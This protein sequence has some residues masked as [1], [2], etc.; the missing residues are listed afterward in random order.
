MFRILYNVKAGWKCNRGS[1]IGTRASLL[2]I[3]SSIYC[4]TLFQMTE[5]TS[6]LI[7]EQSLSPLL[8]SFTWDSLTELLNLLCWSEAG[9]QR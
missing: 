4:I 3:Q 6:V 8:P 2:K 5:K 1:G 7:T 9:E